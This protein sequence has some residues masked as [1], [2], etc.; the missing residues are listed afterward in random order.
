M[1]FSEFARLKRTESGVSIAQCA[2]AMG[3][4]PDG[5]LKKE[6]AARGWSLE[7]A[8]RL[9]ALYGLR[10]SQLLSE[11]ENGNNIK[12]RSTKTNA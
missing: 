10:G 3:L 7:Q 9:A 2:A 1:T 5:Y 4:R 12:N 8:V 11:W 6:Q